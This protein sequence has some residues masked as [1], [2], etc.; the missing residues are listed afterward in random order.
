MSIDLWSSSAIP[1]WTRAAAG[2]LT[3]SG[4]PAVF[5]SNSHAWCA[6]RL[7]YL[8]D[9]A[10]VSADDVAKREQRYRAAYDRLALHGAQMQQL[11]ALVD[12]DLAAAGLLWSSIGQREVDAAFTTIMGER[13]PFP[14]VNL[15][16]VAMRYYGL[17]ALGQVAKEL[18]ES[19]AA[20]NDAAW[21]SAGGRCRSCG[22]ATISEGQ[23]GRLR[24][25]LAANPD[26]FDLLPTYRQVSGKEAPLWSARVL[27]AAK[28]V[29][30]HV[31]PWSLGGASTSD[32]LA[33][34]CASCNYSRGDTSLDV[35]RVAAYS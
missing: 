2:T 18:R 10:N 24:K 7:A 19:R 25:I 31:V 4:A 35:V 34:V 14:R 8:A 27:I 26:V 9:V 22:A 15:A 13:E 30:D 28:G 21:T 32:N 6:I 23:Y 29:A 17:D 1:D 12:E 16:T 11:V 5:R 33:N 3:P 20:D